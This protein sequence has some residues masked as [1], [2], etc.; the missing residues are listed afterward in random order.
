MNKDDVKLQANIASAFAFADPNSSNIDFITESLLNKKGSTS[1]LVKKN[2][3]ETLGI[4]GQ[5]RSVN[6]NLK[7]FVKK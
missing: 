3:N 2:V 5:Y 6:V 7:N 1:Q 4:L